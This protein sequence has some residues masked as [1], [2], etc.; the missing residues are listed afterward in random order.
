MSNV[1]D[2][3]LLKKM[4]IRPPSENLSFEHGMWRPSTVAKVSYPEVGNDACFAV[5]DRS[6]WFRH[7]NDV[8]VAAIKRFPPSGPIYDIGGG[9][10]FVSL[11]MEAAGHSVVL[12][13]PGSGAANALRRGV[14]NVVHGSLED[15]AF[16]PSSIAAVAVFD[17]VEHVEHED[18]F[19][20]H[21]HQLLAPS[22]KV[23][24]TVPAARWLWSEEDDLAG[25]FRRYTPAS[26]RQSFVRNGFDVEFLSPFFSWLHLPIFAFRTVPYRLGLRRSGSMG[27]AAVQADHSLPAILRPIAE[28][29]HRWELNRIRR[30]DTVPFGTSLLCVG[31]R[32]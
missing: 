25:H 11:A 9:N 13:E 24:C 20:K 23:Y 22:G 12:V 29:S 26:L 1:D 32:S 21:I 10:G 15:A 17:V 30:G 27:T 18:R 28:T 8:I 14:T 6:Y 31:R 7:R 19:F 16:S 2:A 3:G 4:I 5:E